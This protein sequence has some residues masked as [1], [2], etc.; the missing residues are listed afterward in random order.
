V[1]VE[2]AENIIEIFN[3]SMSSKPMTDYLNHKYPTEEAAE[4]SAQTILKQVN[5]MLK[6]KHTVEEE[7][8]EIKTELD[9]MGQYLCDSSMCKRRYKGVKGLDGDA[10]TLL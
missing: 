4:R 2:F 9:T 6:R 8:I 10:E 3:I 1:Y 5:A 7:L